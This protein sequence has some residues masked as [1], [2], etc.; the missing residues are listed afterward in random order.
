MKQARAPL[1]VSFG[2]GGTDIEPYINDYGGYVLSAAIK[3]Y[4]RAY[5][6]NAEYAS[7]SEIEKLLQQVSGKKVKITSAVKTN[8][9]PH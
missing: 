6:T 1:R 3:L 5:E 4:A 9:V 2:G 7:E 8:T